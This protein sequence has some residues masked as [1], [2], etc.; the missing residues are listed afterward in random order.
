[1]SLTTSACGTSSAPPQ[2]TQAEATKDTTRR[3]AGPPPRDVGTPST[4]S[5]PAPESNSL[6]TLSVERD[7]Q[8]LRLESRGRFHEVVVTP[9]GAV[10]SHHH[11]LWVLASGSGQLTRVELEYGEDPHGFATDG[12]SVF[13]VST[14]G[15]AKLDLETLQREPAPFIP[16]GFSSSVSV[17]D[18][19]YAVGK[20]RQV[21]RSQGEMGSIINTGI[22]HK[23]IVWDGRIRAADRM[24]VLGVLEQDRSSLYRYRIGRKPHRIETKW[25]FPRHWSLRRDGA[26]LYIHSGVVF[27]L[28]KRDQRP[29]KL[30]EDTTI[31]ALCWCGLDACALSD[32]GELRLHPRANGRFRL[33]THV[34]G[35]PKKISCSNSRVALI[36]DDDG[37]SSLHLVSLTPAAG[38]PRADG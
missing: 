35:K 27:R 13:W 26:L 22:D 8:H 29:S 11:A 31:T 28:N 10:F 7:G 6:D 33:V 17:G 3:S 4:P 1:M 19:L 24:F 18:T 25:N 15:P 2:Q 12:Q 9:R 32:T 20:M 16:S 36:M 34:D 5:K 37:E 23:D 21:W 30:F 14:T 38:K